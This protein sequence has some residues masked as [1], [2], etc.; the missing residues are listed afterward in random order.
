ME[1]LPNEQP[2]ST[3]LL[4]VLVI[5]GPTATGKTSLSIEIAK[6]YKGEIISADSRQVYRELTVGSAKILPHE[7]QDVPHHLLDVTSLD[8][9]FSVADFV[10]HARESIQE[11]HS[12]GKLPIIVG[13]TG[14][15]IDSLIYESSFP[16]VPENPEFR[17]ELANY[18]TEDLFL[19]LQK[20]DPERAS[21]IDQHNKVRL[22]RALEIVEQLGKVPVVARSFTSPYHYLY[23]ALRRDSDEHT[24]LIIQRINERWDAM[25]NEVE[26]LLEQGVS[27]GR[28]QGL[29]LEY[30][31]LSYFFEQKL[32]KDQVVTEL[33]Q[34]TKKFVK[35]QYTWWKANPHVLWFHP[36]K[37]QEKILSAITTFINNI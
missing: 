2:D 31:Y 10:A 25:V 1:F 26:K 30:R 19:Q 32:S 20:A 23:L 29:G 24:K 18:S 7:M 12:R 17:K 13:G 21:S 9:N 37:E 35:R 16:E 22:I 15:Y 6:K 3:V 33:A 34:A 27:H 11:I 8:T 4:P 36:E 14:F 28:L 5:A